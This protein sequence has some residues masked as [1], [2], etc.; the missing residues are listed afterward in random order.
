MNKLIVSLVLLLT[1]C[2]LP[3]LPVA[4][5]PTAATPAPSVGSP[6]S[7]IES[8]LPTDG[9][10]KTG[11]DEYMNALKYHPRTVKVVTGNY[12]P[13][14]S[15]GPVLLVAEVLET[16]S[17][18]DKEPSRMRHYTH[19]D[20]SKGTFG[21]VSDATFR[22]DKD[23]VIYPT[24]QDDGAGVFWKPVSIRNDKGATLR[25]VCAQVASK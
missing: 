10:I 11:E 14:F 15:A 2:V 20:C 7:V 24:V 5:E 25:A 3:P 6:R 12:P 19:M 16:A 8:P 1:A 17:H 18:T 23:L 22:A 9:W 21:H 4:P 13:G